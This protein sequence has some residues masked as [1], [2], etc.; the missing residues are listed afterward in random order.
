[1]ATDVDARILRLFEGFGIEIEYM[2]VGSETLDVLPAADRVLEQAAGSPT[3]D[4]E[5]GTL[6]WSNEL[7]LHVIEL[8]TNGP[9]ATIEGLAPRFQS[10]VDEIDRILGPLGGRLLSTAAHPWMNP[11]RETRLWP[12]EY[13]PVYRTF[14][15]IFGCRGHGWTPRLCQ[16]TR[17]C[18][19]RF[20]GGTPD[21]QKRGYAV[22]GRRHR[23]CN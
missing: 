1:M 21:H 9:A 18:Q 23:Y 17:R 12:H 6:S 13:S 20:R 2:I 10:G 15:R 8:K 5:R 7:V 16:C 19:L 4:V 14:D 3:G 11:L 22:A